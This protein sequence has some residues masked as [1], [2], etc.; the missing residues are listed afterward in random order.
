MSSGNDIHVKVETALLSAAAASGDDGKGAACLIPVSGE[1]LI[2]LQIKQLVKAGIRKFLIE[3]DVVS[4]AIVAVAD[5]MKQRGIDIEFIRSPAD[6]G[7]K[8]GMGELLFVMADGVIADDAVLAEMVQQPSAYIVTLD[9]RKENE[10][11]ER[12]DLNSFWGGLA[13]LDHRSISAIAALPDE[14]S[15]DSSLLRQALQDKITHRPL[16]Q[17][18]LDGKQ[19]RLIT[20][21]SEGAALTR[22]LL[23]KKAHHGDG[24]IEAQ[25]FGPL[26][27]KIAPIFWKTPSAKIGLDGAGLLSALGAIALGWTGYPGLSIA[28][29]LICCFL[30]KLRD[31]LQEEAKIDH[32][33]ALLGHGL[34][35]LLALAVFAISWAE[36]AMRPEALFAPTIFI[37]LSLYIKKATSS[38]WYKSIA[39][40][41]A[42]LALLLLVMAIFDAWGFAIKLLILSQLSILLL[43]EYFSSNKKQA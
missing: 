31:L 12:I 8:L 10:R 23:A 28:L 14:W 26:A 29:I 1:P 34:W 7:G 32:V 9:G 20:S 18:L 27:A 3:V 40:S 39:A 24:V 30:I 21:V 11:F 43:P 33:G 35:L 41:P 42:L 25:F 15:I 16:N 13:L 5:Q 4:G 17:Q 6:L 2:A 36:D 19:L 37:L 22:E 38:S